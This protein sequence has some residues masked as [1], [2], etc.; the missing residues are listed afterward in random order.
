MPYEHKITD[1]DL[2]I[3]KKQKSVQQ[4]YYRLKEM[5]PKTPIDSLKRTRILL[6]DKVEIFSDKQQ[7]LAKLIAQG[8][9]AWEAVVRAGYAWRPWFRESSCNNATKIKDSLISHFKVKAVPKVNK[10]A[11]KLKEYSI[12]QLG[13]D[14]TWLLNEQVNL[15]YITK[16]EKQYTVAARLLDNIAT[17][18]DVDAKASN[19]VTIEHEVDYSKILN[20]AKK[21]L[22][23]VSA[24]E[25]TKEEPKL[26]ETIIETTGEIIEVG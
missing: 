25:I 23:F 7:E 13:I 1:A 21:R 15:Y 19:K 18:V 5:E 12:E 26:V 10:L 8:F 3:S 6:D 17:H 14:K 20:E 4:L 11:N 22:E 2:D 16:N 24:P 9:P